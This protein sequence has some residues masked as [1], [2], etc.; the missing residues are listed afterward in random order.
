MVPDIAL[1]SGTIFSTSLKLE[2]N[3]LNKIILM[4]NEIKVQSWEHFKEEISKL[5]AHRALQERI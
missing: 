4:K 2:I 1:V 5:E 3:V